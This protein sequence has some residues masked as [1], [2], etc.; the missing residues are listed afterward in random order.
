MKKLYLFTI[1]FFLTAVT[2]AQV[3]AGL[4]TKLAVAKTPKDKITALNN[5]AISYML[6]GINDSLAAVYDQKQMVIATQSHDEE[7]ITKTELL[8]A[9]RWMSYVG[10]NEVER[11][12]K[13]IVFYTDA[14]A[15]A[16]KYHQHNLETGA[17]LQLS[18]Y[19]R[20]SRINQ[21]DKSVEMV[22]KARGILKTNPNDSLTAIA[23][24][25]SAAICKARGDQLNAFR[26]YSRALATA[27]SIG[28]NSLISDLYIS[29][30][31]FYS[32]LEDNDKALD[33]FL[34]CKKVIKDAHIQ[35]T[36]ENINIYRL[37]GS[38]YSDKKDYHTARKYFREMYAK[39][40]EHH[41]HEAIL[42][43]PLFLIEGT[44]LEEKNYK[45]LMVYMRNPDLIKIIKQYQQ[46]YL[47][48]W[49][50]GEM[51][52]EQNKLDSARAYYNSVLEPAQRLAP[53]ATLLRLYVSYGFFEIKT[54]NAAS[55]LA[56]ME[57]AKDISLKINDIS[58]YPYI[59]HNLDSAYARADNKSKAYDYRV[60]YDQYNARLKDQSRSRQLLLAEVNAE[61]Q[62]IKVQ[63][64]KEEEALSKKHNLQYMGITAAIATVF[65]LLILAGVF[66]TSARIIHGL[67]FFAFI[68][69]FEFITLLCDHVIHEWTHGDPLKIMAIKIVF[70]A[71]LLPVH[72]Y[73]EEKV[74][75][76]LIHR[77]KI[78]LNKLINRSKHMDD[79]ASEAVLATDQTTH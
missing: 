76:H 27:E 42:N 59:Y 14:V 11:L 64:Q 68:F 5:I 13:S 15:N 52:D 32:I 67:G 45:E 16:Q 62:R 57:K 66:T 23:Y 54:G 33:Y 63:Q 51:F 43:Q 18:S 7:L 65:I 19:Y 61:S 22:Q 77:K 72:H 41:F 3:P 60:L 38:V 35:T 9:R 20:R 10:V 70:V 39:A 56:W 28:N 17:Y 48:N 46:E 30:G 75:H 79:I 78:K 8:I 69:F 50:K 4:Q 55:G 25:S 31:M 44:Y 1:L 34:K 40:K 21:V 26:N 49:Y 37:I 6:N 53:P 36:E 24:A 71:L 73:V 58:I 74:I 2:F 47:M 12:K 29:L